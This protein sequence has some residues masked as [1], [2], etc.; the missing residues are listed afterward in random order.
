MLSAPG[1]RVHTD[2]NQRGS[3]EV[4]LLRDR[5]DAYWVA[6]ELHMLMMAW[7]PVKRGLGAVR[8]RVDRV[9]WK[10]VI[11]VGKAGSGPADRTARL[12]ESATDALDTVLIVLDD[13]GAQ[14]HVTRHIRRMARRRILRLMQRIVELGELPLERWIATSQS[15]ASWAKDLE[16]D[17]HKQPIPPEDA[18]AETRGEYTFDAVQRRGEEEAAALGLR[19]PSPEAT[20]PSTQA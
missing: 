20:P 9:L 4:S 11:A 3:S 18:A 6:I 7:I 12:L 16:D 1:M 10:A 5:L 14:G 8:Q 17:A 2:Q 19:E 13:L 15:R